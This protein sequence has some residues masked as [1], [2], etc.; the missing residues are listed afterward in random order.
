METKETFL[1]IEFCG[2]ESH[3]EIH[4]NRYNLAIAIAISILEDDVLQAIVL[5]GLAG[6]FLERPELKDKVYQIIVDT[7]V[8]H[9]EA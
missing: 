1:K 5:T 8:K 9:K 7:E 4:G 2:D 3:V 6:A